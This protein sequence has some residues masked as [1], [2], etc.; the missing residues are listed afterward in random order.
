MTSPATT[1]R[2]SD[3]RIL[4]II[5]IVLGVVALFFVPIVLGPVGAVLGFVA[6][7]RGDRPL[8]M[9]AGIWCIVATILGFVLA[10]AFLHAAGS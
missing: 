1:T 7:A 4:T 3:A 6:M 10:A 5:S 9:W 8:G 2:H